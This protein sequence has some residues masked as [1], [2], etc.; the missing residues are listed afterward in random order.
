MSE[1]ITA[2]DNYESYLKK[3]CDA[4]KITKAEAER[5]LVVKL[6]KQYY[7]DRSNGKV[8]NGFI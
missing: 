5:H 6:V 3:Y 2:E 8:D 4:Y 7:I 1:T